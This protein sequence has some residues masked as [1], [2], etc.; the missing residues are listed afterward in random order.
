[1]LCGQVHC[2]F[3]TRIEYRFLERRARTPQRPGL[4]QELRYD[5][6]I[7][8]SCFASLRNLS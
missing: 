5:Y 6:A 8:V 1:M 2:T 7:H 3:Q 4:A